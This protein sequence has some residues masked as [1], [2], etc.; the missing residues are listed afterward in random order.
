MFPLSRK[1]TNRMGEAEENS[2]LSLLLHIALSRLAL[3]A[4]KYNQGDIIRRN[5]V[6]NLILTA[7]PSAS[8]V[9][10]LPE[11]K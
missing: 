2:A 1:D 9:S 10:R 4:L 6:L 11:V 7:D 5:L 3:S 8:Y